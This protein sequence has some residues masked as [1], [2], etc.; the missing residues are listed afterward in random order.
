MAGVLVRSAVPADADAVAR[1]WI[2]GWRIAYRGLVPDRVI[3]SLRLEDR[4][5]VWRARLTDGDPQARTSVV[6]AGDLVAGYCRIATPSRDDDAGPRTAEIASIYVAADRRRQALGHRL[7]S[8]VLG[9][10]RRDGWT[11]VTLW[12]FTENTGARAF[13]TTHGFAPD[14]RTGH[15]ELCQLDEL[16]LR[17]KP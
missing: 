7:L 9:E 8:T 2:D 10:L 17:A 4:Q 3:D 13:Y 11:A 16:R 6:V 1:I 12:V 14:G 5:A 15:D